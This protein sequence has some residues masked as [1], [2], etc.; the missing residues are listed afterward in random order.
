MPSAIGLRVYQINVSLR[1]DPTALPIDEP[2]L[3]QALKPFL[4]AFVAS[5][6]QAV[7]NT[8][9]ERSWYFQEKK[10]DG[11]GKSRG[12]VHYGTYGFASRMVDTI[13][14][15]T[16]YNRTVTDVEEVP[17]YYE[18]WSPD[19]GKHAL[20][21]FQSFEGR[22]CVSLVMNAMK[23]AFEA[24]NP[25]YLLRYFKLLPNDRRGSLYEASG[26]KRVHLIKRN[27]SGDLANRVMNEPRP[28]NMEIILSAY[29]KQSLGPLGE[30]TKAI[31]ENVE[32]LFVYEGMKFDE[33]SADIKIGNRTLPVGIF[34]GDGN[35]GVIEL[36]DVVEKG[37]DGHPEFDSMA[38]HTQ[39]IL[40][41]FQSI[42][43]GAPA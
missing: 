10:A 43:S 30:I 2:S 15:M 23:E 3:R 4:T 16:N 31:R 18:I 29:K 24:A 42:L 22:S 28:V 6:R 34:G 38:E 17:L 8:E 1:G 13:T 36:T 19:H 33:V 26:V 25:G 14:Q 35:A 37:A 7:Q 39:N 9:M 41:H 11:S 40:V 12:Y 20:V 32:G 21:A 27:A 5:K